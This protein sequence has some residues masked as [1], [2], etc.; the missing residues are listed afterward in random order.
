[1]IWLKSCPRCQGDLF[2]AVDEHER[3]AACLQSG[4]YLISAQ[5]AAL[6]A[7]VFVPN[8]PGENGVDVQPDS[9]RSATETRGAAVFGG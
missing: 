5:L 6:D 4:H 1:M 3:F 8:A 2:D 9:S 7:G